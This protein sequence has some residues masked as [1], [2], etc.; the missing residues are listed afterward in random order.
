LTKMN[1]CGNCG[2]QSKE[3]HNFCENCGSSLIREDKQESEEQVEIV[4]SVEEKPVQKRMRKKKTDKTDDSFTWEKEISIIGNPAVKKQ[5]IQMIFFTGFL[6]AFLMSFLFL[7]TGEP[8]AIPPM[9]GIAVLCMIGLGIFL[10]LIIVIF[11]NNKF[12]VRFTVDE[13]GVLWETID[14][15]AKLVNKAAAVGGALALNPQAAGAGL[16]GMSRE[17]EYTPW[18]IVSKAEYYPRHHT[19]N[20]RNSWRTVMTIVCQPEDYQQIA[21]YTANQVSLQQ[22]SVTYVKKQKNPLTIMLWRTVS[23]ILASVPIFT[24]VHEHHSD[25]FFPLIMFVFALATI[26]I[27]PLL[28]WVVIGS[29]MLV[30]F[31]IF[32]IMFT[33]RKSMFAWRGTYLAYEVFDSGDWFLLFLTLAGLSYLVWISWRSV[34]GKMLS[35]LMEN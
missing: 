24:F 33:E 5:F 21:D 19:I 34:R 30:G 35:A 22:T 29:A 15:R 20:L 14:K 23:V 31:E 4:E 18:G 27:V 13:K 10:F 9:L 3:G 17:N 32:T 1:F 16:I 8:E 11:F 7:V 26:W 25:I 28:G 6:M 2:T 12:K